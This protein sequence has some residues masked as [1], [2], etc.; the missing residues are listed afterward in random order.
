MLRDADVVDS[1]FI[2]YESVCVG[3]WLG[4]AVTVVGADVFCCVGDAG[5]DSR[6]RVMPRAGVTPWTLAYGVGVH[7]INLFM[8]SPRAE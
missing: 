7:F 6:L 8:S 3:R 4:H 2:S 5:Q 1:I